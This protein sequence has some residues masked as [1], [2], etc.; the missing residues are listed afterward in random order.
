MR[1][2][3][4]KLPAKKGWRVRRR[5]VDISAVNVTKAQPAFTP[6]STAFRSKKRYLG[7][8]KIVLRRYE[9]TADG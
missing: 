9:L 5:D 2:S 7:E 8:L 3:L 4:K 6:G 1:I